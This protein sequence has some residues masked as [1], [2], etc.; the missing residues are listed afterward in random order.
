MTAVWSETHNNVQVTKG[1]FSVNLGSIDFVLNPLTSAILDGDRWLQVEVNGEVLG[2][3]QPLTSAPYSI[4]ADVAE[5][6][7]SYVSTDLFAL[8]EDEIVSGV[9]SFN[10]G[11]PGITPPFNVN[12]DT[13]VTNLNAD[14]LDGQD[15]SAFMS[16]STDNWVDTTGDTMSGSSAT[17]VLSVTNTAVTGAGSGV[18]GVTSAPNGSGVR[19]TASGLQGKGISGRATGNLGR[20]V[21]GD[22]TGSA[23][24][25]VQGNAAG[26]D[27]RGVFGWAGD[28]TGPGPN[29]GGYFQADG[30]SGR[31]VYGNASGP[32]GQGVSGIASHPDDVENY[33]GH[34]TAAG[35][36]GRGVYGLAEAASGTN[37]G[38]YFVAEGP[39]GSGVYGEATDTGPG[40]NHGGYFLANSGLGRGVYGKASG[41]N[42]IGVAGEASASSTNG[43]GV[44]GQ[45]L[46]IGSGI[47]AGVR[48]N[49]LANNGYGV[50]G[51]NNNF[52]VGVG[53]W[54]NHGN[55]IEAYDG[56][57]PIGTI[58]FYVNQGGDAWA[59]GIHLTFTGAHEGKLADDFPEHVEAGMIVSVTGITQ[60][61]RT[62]DGTISISTTLPTVKLSQKPND[63][64]VFGVVV[65]EAPLHEKHWYQAKDGERFATV[66]ALGEGRVWVSNINGDIQAGDY[67][68]TSSI[69][70]Y[71]Q[72][73]D[74]DLLH[75]Y[76]LGK[77]IE[78]V[79][80]DSVTETIDFN[81][82]TYKIYLIAVVYTSG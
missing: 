80:W 5:S 32:N 79:D 21:F 34:F 70:G 66:N 9:P 23:G 17:E 22:A 19:G 82:Q 27:G 76:T 46:S 53:A 61:R 81:G 36:Q 54:S 57:F 71:G 75:S 30:P 55:L 68:T 14:S 48:G 3:R 25:G 13:V 56:N 58:R 24:F 31:G 42:G 44:F 26:A 29:Y 45:S 8:D 33:G 60:I 12:S 35:A 4:R 52:G 7:D 37:Y 6:L 38:G 62:E 64:A 18:S 65:G 63:K 39:T 10:G 15:S 77:A 16:A 49:S 72:M 41:S 69:P 74:D 67:I 59:D 28:S 20:G 2:P 43:T 78:N 40:R 1:I 50:V 11:S 73:Q 51:S 47:P